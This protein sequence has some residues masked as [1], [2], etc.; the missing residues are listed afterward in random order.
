[1]VT[2]KLK[3]IHNNIYYYECFPENKETNLFTIG[4]DFDKKELVYLSLPEMN[5][6]VSH[7]KWRLLKTYEETNHIPEH[8]TSVWY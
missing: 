4:I 5:N 3:N 7:A 6:Y 2:M 8:E 1:M